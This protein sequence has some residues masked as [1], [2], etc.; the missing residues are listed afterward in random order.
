MGY[1]KEALK[2]KLVALYPEIE[3]Y[4]LSTDLEF[5]EN[6]NAWVVSFSKG[7]LTRHAF[8]EKSDADACMEG[9]ACIYLGVLIEQYI[10]DMEARL[11][12]G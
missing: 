7:A 5:D 1:N 2:E 6:K 11:G 3:K 10:K 12:E 9:N 8:L 4:G